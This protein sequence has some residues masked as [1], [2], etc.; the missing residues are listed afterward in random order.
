MIYGRVLVCRSHI[1]LLKSEKIVKNL[2]ISST[3]PRGSVVQFQ[4]VIAFYLL[5]SHIPL[6]RKGGGALR[7]LHIACH[8]VSDVLVKS[9][10][11]E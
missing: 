3:M 8:P 11:E 5:G 7:H 6:Q 10:K 1:A 2:I 4:F 9:S